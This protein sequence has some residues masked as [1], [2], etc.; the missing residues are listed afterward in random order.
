MTQPPNLIVTPGQPIQADTW[1]A[2]MR[3]AANC[4]LMAGKNCYLTQTSIGTII[5]FR[6][7]RSP[8]IHPFRVTMN[9]DSVAVEPGLVNQVMATIDDEPLD[10]D[11]PPELDISKPQFDKNGRGW[12][13][14]EI[15]CKT[16]WSVD[17]VEI[18]QVADL[19]SV[20]GSEMAQPTISLGGAPNLK[21]RRAR[22]AIAMLRQ[23]KD[24]V[25]KLYQAVMHDLQHRV[26]TEGDGSTDA[27]RHFFFPV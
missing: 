14:I 12:I 22:W 20:D 8:R 19:E 1:D 13:C 15:A 5:N 7:T 11:D 25:V 23:R 16:D 26:H 27:G 17:T 24:G 18:T 9:E 6:E 21:G 4:R 10:A 3:F 2:G